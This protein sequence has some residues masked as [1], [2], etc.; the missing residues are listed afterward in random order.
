MKITDIKIRKVLNDNKIK[1]IVSV[2]L[3]NCLA[4]HD[5]RIVEGNERI[6][7]AAPS[8]RSADGTYRD[9]VHPINAKFRGEL[10]AQV[11]EHYNAAVSEGRFA[12]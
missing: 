3:D 8:K 11:L 9:I 4:I 2:T 5:I 12:N 6:F 7:V 1:A 10:E